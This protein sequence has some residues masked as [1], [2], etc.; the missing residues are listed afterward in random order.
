VAAIRGFNAID[1]SGAVPRP[2]VLIVARGGGSI[3]DLWCFN[4][5]AVVRATAESEIPLISAVGHETDT[6]LID[7]ASDKRAPTPTAAAEMAV[8]VRAELIYDVTNLQQRLLGGLNRRMREARGE[9][10]AARRG[11]RDPRDALGLATQ[12]LDEAS[13]RLDRALGGGVER[14][15]GALREAASGLRPSVLHDRSA[16]ART[17]TATAA[18]GLVRSLVGDVRHHRTTFDNRAGRLQPRLVVEALSEAQGRTVRAATALD[19]DM[20]QRLDGAK[21]SVEAQVRLLRTLSYQNVLERG[22]AL[23]RDGDRDCP[24]K[25]VAETGAGDAVVIEFSDGFVGATVGGDPP[26]KK[27][28]PVPRKAPRRGKSPDGGQGD[29]F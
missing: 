28:T 23:V 24:I 29:F 5:E 27:E 25:R 10:Q 19:R 20:T 26:A 1:G 22:F 16:V 8:P 18:R 9:L 4:E 12:Q 17:R 11:L 21:E 2:D 13:L 15:R 7:Y 6:T 14:R 3:E